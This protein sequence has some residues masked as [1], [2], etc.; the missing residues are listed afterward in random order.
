MTAADDAAEQR[1][2]D[3]RAGRAGPMEEAARKIMADNP[4]LAAELGIDE[5]VQEQDSERREKDGPP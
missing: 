3:L 1:L 4:A 2:A 5:L